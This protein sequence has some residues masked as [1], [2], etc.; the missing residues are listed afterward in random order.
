MQ[1]NEQMDIQAETLKGDIRDSI[2]TE[3]KHTAKPWQQM[4][5]DE[6]QRMID[7][8][9]DIS[10]TVIQRSINI[11]AERG[12]PS[13]TI[14]VGKFTVDAGELKG[15]FEAYASD[16][17]LLRVRHLAE[18]RAIFVL[19]SPEAYQGEKA[20]AETEN[21]GELALPKTG[22]GAP[23]DPDAL[24]NVGR[25]KRKNGADDSTAATT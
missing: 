1:A 22:P 16:E 23:S 25:G 12:L 14:T 9:V 2:L 13:M 4:T 10:H 7:R 18:Q 20:P 24:K 19:A 3:F 8:S 15:T 6:Q 5:E 11:I 17:N 21:V